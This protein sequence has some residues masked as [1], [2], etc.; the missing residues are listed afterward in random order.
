MILSRWGPIY[1]IVL[2]YQGIPFL[3]T[4]TLF[5]LRTHVLLPI[6]QNEDTYQE[7]AYAD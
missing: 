1:T 2:F 7:I 5:H 6:I 3:I 4:I